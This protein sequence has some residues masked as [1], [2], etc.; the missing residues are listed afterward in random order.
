MAAT[1]NQQ[2]NLEKVLAEVLYQ[3]TGKDLLTHR[4]LHDN[5]VNCSFGDYAFSFDTQ[6]EYDFF[7]KLYDK[8]RVH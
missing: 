3:H 6:E 2:R 1:D 4:I 5:T 7:K 8:I